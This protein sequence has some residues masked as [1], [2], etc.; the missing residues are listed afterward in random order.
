MSKTLRTMFPESLKIVYWNWDNQLRIRTERELY[1]QLEGRVAS[2]PFAGM[3]YIDICA[4]SGP[5]CKYLGIYEQEL[6]SVMKS[7]IDSAPPCH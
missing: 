4:G 7:F 6:C 3:H 1:Q 2:G 5:A